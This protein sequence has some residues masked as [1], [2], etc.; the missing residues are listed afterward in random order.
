MTLSA[1]KAAEILHDAYRTD[2][3]FPDDLGGK[4]TLGQAMMRSL[5]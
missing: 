5:H 1:E 4:L 2:S 3:Y